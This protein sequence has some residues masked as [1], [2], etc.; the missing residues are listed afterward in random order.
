M[1]K[2][3]AIIGGGAAG[4]FCAINIMKQTGDTEIVIHE[5]GKR[6]LSKVSMSGGGRCNLTNTFDNVTNLADA[7]PRG[8]IL[9]KR[10]FHVFD[11]EDTFKWFQDNGC[12]L[13]VEDDNRIFPEG[14]S[15][16]SVVK[17]LYGL[18]IR[19]NVKIFTESQIS[20]IEKYPGGYILSSTTGKTYN[21][22]YVIVTVGGCSAF[23]KNF[24]MKNLNLDIKTPIPS[25]FSMRISDK[26]L[27]SLAGLSVKN[28]ILTIPGTK[29]ISYGDLLITNRGISGPAVLKLSSHAAEFLNEN[30]YEAEININWTGMADEEKIRKDIHDLFSKNKNKA[31]KSVHLE[32]IPSRLWNFL[33][34]KAEIKSEL[35]CC[36]I[37]RKNINKMVS[38]LKRDFYTMTGRDRNKDEFVT[39]GGVSLSNINLNTLESKENEGIFFAGEILDVDAIT[40]GFNLQAAWTTGY[41]VAMSVTS[42][43]RQEQGR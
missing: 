21:Y 39:C 5:S 42:K 25:L 17:T 10:L 29:F 2:R 11:P 36:E 40:G 24:L 6:L 27:T 14:N 22:D 31:I 32:K 4:C 18:L 13:K 12:K 19:N 23:H 34:G 33:A 1:P 16:E 8:N 30:N 15:S 43:I 41:V 28:V 38:A 20:D 37:S 3:I 7:Y 26:R 35:P 9:L